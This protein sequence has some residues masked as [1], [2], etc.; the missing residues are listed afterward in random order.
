M[1][2]RK[3]RGRPVNGVLVVNKPTGMTSND[4]LQQAKRLLFAAKAGHT[5]ALD[6]LA[7]GVLPLCF[8]EATKFSQFLLDADKRYRT[9]YQLG[10]FSTTG[11]ADGE[12]LDAVSAAGVTREQVWQALQPFIGDILQVPPMYSALKHNGE[13][14]YKLARQGIEIEREARPVTVYSIELLDFRGGEQAQVDLD[15]HCSKGTYIRSIAEDLGKALGVGAHVVKLHRT[16]AGAFTEADM[17]ELD[18]LREERGEQLA[19]VLDHHLLP[20]D[21]PVQELPALTL[22]EDSAYYFRQGNPVMDPQVYRLGQEGD[23]VRVFAESGDFLGVG[24]LDDEGRV[25]P[26]RLVV[27]S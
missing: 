19:E 12:L 6:P 17:L 10:A 14:L 22:L 15:I 3:A 26:K 5:G 27:S 11:D 16:Q 18:D 20:V 2:R 25:A 23:M 24:V 13:P 9:T 7:T 4:A 21:T 1:A 8:G